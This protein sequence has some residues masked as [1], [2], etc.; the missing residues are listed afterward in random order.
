MQGR[1]TFI[2]NADCNVLYHF[3]KQ[4]PTS[5][6]NLLVE[7]HG[8]ITLEHL[9]LPTNQVYDFEIII[10]NIKVQGDVSFKEAIVPYI[11]QELHIFVKPISFKPITSP[12]SSSP[13][14]VCQ[15][16]NDQIKTTANK[17]LYKKNYIFQMHFINK[18]I[19]PLSKNLEIRSIENAQCPIEIKPNKIG[20][21]VRMGY[22][23]YALC[24]ARVKKGKTLLSNTIY[25]C[26]CGIFDPST[27]QKVSVNQMVLYIEYNEHQQENNKN[28]FINTTNYI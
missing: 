23:N 17:S 3:C 24:Q 14:Y 19:Y 10:S 22:Q 26:E 5:F 7:L 12:I 15:I 25:K 2:V 18:G 21:D 16:I 6:I 4:R 13:K 8:H 9:G 1:N 11:N 20:V 27:N 28:D